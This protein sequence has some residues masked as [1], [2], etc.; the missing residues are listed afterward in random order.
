M[1]TKKTPSQKMQEQALARDIL[2]VTGTDHI[3][4]VSGDPKRPIWR[5]SWGVIPNMYKIKLDYYDWNRVQ[6]LDADGNDISGKTFTRTLENEANDK[7]AADKVSAFEAEKAANDAEK[8]RAA[9]MVTRY[10][11]IPLLPTKQ[12]VEADGGLYRVIQWRME[13]GYPIPPELM[14]LKNY[15]WTRVVFIPIPEPPPLSTISELNPSDFDEEIII[16]NDKNNNSIYMYSAIAAI[17]LLF[18]R[19]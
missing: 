13:W 1:S 16:K 3:Q 9:E 6:Y 14:T 18:S 17:L 2:Q 5:T 8:D 12:R 11:G 10:I 4:S 19:S 15:D 7:A